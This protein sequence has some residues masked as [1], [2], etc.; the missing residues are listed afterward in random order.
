MDSTFDINNIKER[1][2]NRAT[3]I[4]MRNSSSKMKE[5][6]DG[7]FAPLIIVTKIMKRIISSTFELETGRIKLSCR[8]KDQQ[9]EKI[10][11]YAFV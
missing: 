7:T 10:Y 3:T 9:T 8:L 4:P 1:K 11:L 2:T 6:T 5:N